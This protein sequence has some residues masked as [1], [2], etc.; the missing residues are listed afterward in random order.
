[1]QA[2]AVLLLL[3]VGM[4]APLLGLAATVQ[5]QQSVHST[6]ERVPV[7]P[8]L[9]MSHPRLARAD[10]ATP[11]TPEQVC[12]RFPPP[13]P[14]PAIASEGAANGWSVWMAAAAGASHP[15]PSRRRLLVGCR[16]QQCC[17]LAA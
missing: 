7:V 16:R 6:Y 3:V 8:Q 15:P 2:A 12:A 10:D 5:Q 1:M 4:A 9:G 17:R 13:M 14:S 11:H